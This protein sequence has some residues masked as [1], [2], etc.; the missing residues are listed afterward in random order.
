MP[1]SRHD[2]EGGIIS[3]W[4]RLRPL[5]VGVVMA[6]DLVTGII[7]PWRGAGAR[8]FATRPSLVTYRDIGHTSVVAFLLRPRRESHWQCN[9]E[10]SPFLTRRSIAD[11]APPPAPARRT[12][13]AGAP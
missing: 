2:R 9:L 4:W 13:A 7:S 1:V 11:A 3:P 12:A 5:G 8:C 6:R 10:L